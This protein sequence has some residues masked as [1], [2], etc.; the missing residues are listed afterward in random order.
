MRSAVRTTSYGYIVPGNYGDIMSY[1]GALPEITPTRASAAA[2]S[3]LRCQRLG[4]HQPLDERYCATSLPVI[5]RPRSAAAAV[6]Q[7]GAESNQG[8]T[9]PNGRYNFIYQTDGNL[10]LYGKLGALWASGTY[11]RG[12]AR[13]VM[14][15]DGNLVV[16]NGSN[17]PLWASGTF[18][19]PGAT[20][21]VQDDGNVVIYRADH[22]AIW[23]T[24]TVQ[25]AGF[26]NG[27][28]QI[29]NVN[30][31]KCVDVAWAATADGA[32]IQQANCSG[33]AAQLFNGGHGR[34]LVPLHQR[35]QRPGDG[36]P[37]AR[38]PT[39]PTSA[40]G[41]TTFPARSVL[42]CATRQRRI[43]HRQHE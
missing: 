11:G 5:A 9:S 16:Y 38:P 17:Q 18:G 15:G 19:N 1:A 32:N 7:A 36:R 12:V 2:R 20:L 8:I 31:G 43:H 39:A 41:A 40:S 30:S 35:Q 22:A 37:T 33:N 21:A 26:G 6:W 29:Q 3:G 25:R 13:A 24:N 34:R 4:R 10:V 27:R 23:A 14:Q 28:Y 42:P